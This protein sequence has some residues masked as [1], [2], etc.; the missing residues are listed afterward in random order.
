VAAKWRGPLRA[1]DVIAIE[2]PGGGGYGSSDQAELGQSREASS[3]PT[4]VQME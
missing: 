1:G 3:T 2:T 4:S